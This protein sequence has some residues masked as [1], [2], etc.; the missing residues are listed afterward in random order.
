M[1]ARERDE[2]IGKKQSHLQ[3][4]EIYHTLLLAL[5]AHPP[6]WLWFTGLKYLMT[7]LQRQAEGMRLSVASQLF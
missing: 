7:T 5:E 6:F 4:L 1:R 3:N 2:E